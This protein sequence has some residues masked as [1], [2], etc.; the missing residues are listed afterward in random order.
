MKNSYLL[1]GAGLAF[2]IVITGV[3]L[4][5]EPKKDSSVSEKI[6]VALEG[7]GAV[8]VIDGNKSKLVKTISLTDE[9]TGTMYMPHNVQVSLDGSVVWVTA[10]AMAEMEH[11]SFRFLKTAQ[12]DGGH[13][14]SE[15]ESDQLI[16]IDPSTDM[17]VRR[18]PIAIGQHLAHVV[19]SATD[20]TVFVAAQETDMIYVVDADSMTL[21]RSIKLPEGSGPH[22]M[23]LSPDDQTLYVALMSGEALGMVDINSGT[24]DS[25]PLNGGA[26]QTAV[27]PD[28]SRVAVSVYDSLSIGV[29][30]TGKRSLSYIKLP[31]GSQGPVQLY[32][33][34]DSRFVYVADQGTLN[35][36]RANDKLFKIDLETL[37]VAET[38]E[39]GRAPHGVALNRGGDRVYVT[40]L[41]D[42]SVSV[43]DTGAGQ[44]I[45]R[46]NVGKEPNGVSVWNGREDRSSVGALEGVKIT[47]YKSPTCGCCGNY[48]AEL[49]RQGA[50]ITVEEISEAA[51]T[52]KKAA[53]GVRPELESCHTSVMDGYVIEG[54]VPVEAIAKLRAE[55][56]PLAG[57]ALPGM[58]A[59]SPGMS[60][61]KSE[62][63]AVQT[64]EGDLFGNF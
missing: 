31:E 18:I 50:E 21:E 46:V 6:Y 47:V 8:G 4:Y 1:V 63:F 20:S 22:G 48:V 10:N 56:P 60:G 53:L 29:Y 23:R 27:T 37:A 51:L 9:R 52:E 28:G 7:D 3:M 41:E 24:V 55:R 64:L 39:V 17:I 26:V 36:R 54:H 38:I 61:I 40:N 59:G 58:P 34:K 44:E 15:T 45:A 42:G 16:A 30:D 35:G 12:A 33:T 32:P 14:D 2:V 43:I 19:Q 57:I 11:Q 5:L 49:G 13:E 25:Q 62:P